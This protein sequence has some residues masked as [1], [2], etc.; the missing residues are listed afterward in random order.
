MGVDIVFRGMI[1]IWLA[2][3]DCPIIRGHTHC[4]GHGG[5]AQGGSGS[6]SSEWAIRGKLAASFTVALAQRTC[7]MMVVVIKHEHALE[8]RV[9]APVQDEA[10]GGSWRFSF[11]GWDDP[12]AVGSGAAARGVTAFFP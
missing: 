1:V 8:S 7:E 9:A 4:G 12:N 10:N 2:K 5:D 3:I 6:L 11:S